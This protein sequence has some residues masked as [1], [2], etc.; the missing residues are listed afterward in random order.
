MKREVRSPLSSIRRQRLERSTSIKTRPVCLCRAHGRL[1]SFSPGVLFAALCTL[2]LL[3]GGQLPAQ[4]KASR[5]GAEDKKTASPRV[6]ELPAGVVARVNGREVTLE[7]YSQFLLELVGKKK[8][9][10]LVDRILVEQEARR[11]GVALEPEEVSLAVD[12]EFEQ[13]VRVLH[14][15]DRVKFETWL[16]KR[17]GISVAE[18]KEGQRQQKAFELLRDQCIVHTRTIGKKEIN[19]EFE[20]QYGEGGVQ[21][22]LRHILVSTRPIL[23]RSRKKRAQ[24]LSDTEARAKAEKLIEELKGGAEFVDLVKQHSDDPLTRRND[25]RIPIY[26]K[27]I[28]GPE[29]STAV[30]KLSEENRLSSVV[31]SNRG[32]HI[33]YFIRK[34]TTKL[35]DKREEIVK[36]LKTRTPGAAER[37]RYTRKLRDS[38]KVKM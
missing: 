25:G 34:T 18:Y 10:E 14:Q 29:F 23:M 30:E 7:E 27:N 19:L 15:G 36:S 38:S 2:M 5:G 6:E 35:E 37:Q 31:R 11:L 33:V 21:Y 32:Y 22:E 9:W 17:Y 20:K 1:L 26:R 16:R 12:E 24:P 13:K 8:L 4:E 28:Y 3:P